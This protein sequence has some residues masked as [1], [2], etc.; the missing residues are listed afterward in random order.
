MMNHGIRRT[1][2][3]RIMENQY[4]EPIAKLLRQVGLTE[5]I[6]WQTQAIVLAGILLLSWLTAVLFRRLVIPALQKIS[7]QTRVTWDDH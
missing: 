7:S 4:V 1:E 2:N 3:D 5:Q 6:T